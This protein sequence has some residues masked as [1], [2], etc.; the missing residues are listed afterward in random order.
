MLGLGISC[1]LLLR[2]C[3]MAGQARP[4]HDLSLSWLYWLYSAFRTPLGGI[5]GCLVGTDRGAWI[6]LDWIGLDYW[7]GDPT[8]AEPGEDVSEKWCEY[9][10]VVRWCC[11]WYSRGLD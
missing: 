2:V 7:M 8:A 1:L 10:A 11:L 5:D 3:A 6:G 4:Y 9:A